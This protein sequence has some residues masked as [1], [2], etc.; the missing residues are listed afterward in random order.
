MACCNLARRFYSCGCRVSITSFY[1]FSDIVTG[2]LERVGDIIGEIE[3]RI[4]GLKEDSEK[5]TVFLELRDR[6]KELEINITYPL[7][8]LHY[9]SICK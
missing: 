3:G 7:K 9:D 2:N 8:V 5:A 1:S 6:Y 4:P